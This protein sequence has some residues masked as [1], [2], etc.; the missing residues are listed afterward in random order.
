MNG[1][2]PPSCFGRARVRAALA[3]GLLAGAVIAGAPAAVAGEIESSLARGGLLYDKWFKVVKAET[4]KVAHPAYPADGKYRGK[5]GADWRCKE[6][7]GWDNLG[8]DGAYSTGKHFSGI[9]GIRGM[10][11][12]DT[13][14][15]VAVLKDDTH[16][17]TDAM[18]DAGDFED[19]ALFVSRGQV[20][21]DRYIDRAS[22]QAKGD[23]VKGEALYNTICANC[24]GADGLTIKE[25]PPMGNVASGNPW[26]ALHKI[27]NGQPGEQ[28]P[29]LR[30]LDHQI[31][32]DILAHSQTLPKKR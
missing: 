5:D 8:K 28:M 21:M 3:A 11:G 23:T 20:D 22:K 16:G 18:M 19:L 4:P 29:A 9:K 2:K 25:M 31:S 26:E 1:N 32:V 17:Y 24:H 13:A 15:I 6:C 10:A 12:A 27:L 7:H 14:N 30:A